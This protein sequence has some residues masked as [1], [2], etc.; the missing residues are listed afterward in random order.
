MTGRYEP[1]T[2]HDD[3][4]RTTANQAP[5]GGPHGIRVVRAFLV[6]LIVIVIGAVLLPSATRGPRL[7]AASNTAAHHGN[8]A[9]TSTTTTRPS[10]TT[11]TLAPVPHSSIK[12]LVANGTTTSHGASEVRT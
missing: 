7:P 5:P 10:V 4:T 12:V 11:T 9:P 1:P 3:E 6:L 8:T 2:G